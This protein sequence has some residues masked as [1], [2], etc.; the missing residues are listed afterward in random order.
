VCDIIPAYTFDS[1]LRN[2][3]IVIHKTYD[4]IFKEFEVVEI[5]L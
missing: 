4:G 2:R 1:V 3:E 5:S